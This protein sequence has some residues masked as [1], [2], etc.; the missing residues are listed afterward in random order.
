MRKLLLLLSF[1]MLLFVTSCK[2]EKDS[3]DG[4]I[5]KWSYSEPGYS[6]SITFVFGESTF[7]MHA[8]ATGVDAP[9][10]ETIPGNYTYDEPNVLLT[11]EVDGEVESIAAVIEG[12]NMLIDIVGDDEKVIFV[13]Q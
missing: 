13:K 6:E 8:T 3:L 7:E 5:W 4:T 10:A 11:A 9:E 2:D 12:N 1:M